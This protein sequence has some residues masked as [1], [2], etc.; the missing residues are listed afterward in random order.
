MQDE[1]KAEAIP[2]VANENPT[3]T[4]EKKD[5]HSEA[6]DREARRL[7]YNLK[8]HDGRSKF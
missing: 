5:E 8:H 2:T 4:P 1:K 6:A 3:T 7:I